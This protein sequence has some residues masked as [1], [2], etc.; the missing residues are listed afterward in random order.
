[1]GFDLRPEA[2]LDLYRGWYF[3]RFGSRR[4]RLTWR[5][6]PAH[7]DAVAPREFQAGKIETES[8]Q[9]RSNGVVPN[10]VIAASSRRRAD[11]HGFQ[12]LHNLGIRI[13]NFGNVLELNEFTLNDR[14]RLE[15]DFGA[16]PVTA[17][18]RAANG[19]RQETN[20]S[21]QGIS[22]RSQLGFH[23]RW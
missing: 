15:D 12:V 11:H 18:C 7:G 21:W 2:V 22:S 20:D 6:T 10:L 1:M 5:G 23:S 16:I 3:N 14:C 9:S 8:Q 4:G 13:A 17:N 19:H